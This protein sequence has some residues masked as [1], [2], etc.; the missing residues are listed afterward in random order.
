MAGN[1]YMFYTLL[2]RTQCVATES[3]TCLKPTGNRC[4]SAES[5]IQAIPAPSTM[6]GLLVIIARLMNTVL[7]VKLYVNPK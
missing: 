5:L 2:T 6:C 1:L 4:F 7:N 3:L